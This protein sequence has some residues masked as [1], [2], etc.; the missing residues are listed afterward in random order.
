MKE[1][2]FSMM[3]LAGSI[4]G[5]ADECKHLWFSQSQQNN[6][7]VKNDFN[8]LDTTKIRVTY[9]KLE[10]GNIVKYTEI[11]DKKEYRPNPNDVQYIGCGSY[12]RTEIIEKNENKYKERLLK[13][14]E[15]INKTSNIENELDCKNGTIWNQR[16][17]R[18]E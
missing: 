1:I 8:A 5:F 12:E 15:E 10:N 17:G 4:N 16:Y 14:Y 18:C 11:T 3:I 13:N 7:F 6:S 2:V 9:G